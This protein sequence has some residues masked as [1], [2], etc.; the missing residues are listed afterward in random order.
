MHE[1]TLNITAI[2]LLTLAAVFVW[3]IRNSTVLRSAESVQA[4]TSRIRTPM[5]W[6]LLGIG[7]VVSYLS[8]S[9]WPHSVANK[10]T[11]IVVT[12]TG[13]QWSWD[14]KPKQVPVG[15]PI[16]F[17]VT[18]TD[19]KSRRRHLRRH[20][21]TSDTDTRNARLHKSREVHVH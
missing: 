21:A 10:E 14:F 12:L 1:T 2:L 9:P 4:G 20:W 6:T 19:V 16:V 18:S 17:A 7:A 11:P 3:V 5:V 8:L 13:A 15:R